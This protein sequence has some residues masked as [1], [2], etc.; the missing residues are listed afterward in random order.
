MSNPFRPVTIPQALETA[1]QAHRAGRLAEADALYRQILSA[2]PFHADALHFLGVIAGQTGKHVE[3]VEWFRQAIVRQPGNP[4]AHKNFSIA[5]K[6][7]GQVDEAISACR[8]AVAIKPDYPEAH[9]ILGGL[10]HAKGTLDEALAAYRQ[11]LALRPGYAESWSNL[12][13]VLRD[14]GQPDEAILACREAIALNNALPEAHSNLGNALFAQ[15]AFGA[16]VAAYRDALRLAPRFASAWNNLG[17]A[18]ESNG[19]IE[20][21]IGA[22]QK[23]IELRPEHAD[24]FAKLGHALKEQGRFAEAMDAYRK[25]VELKP[26]SPDWRHVLAALSGDSSANGTPATYVRTLFDSYA[27]DFD[28]D[29]VEKLAYHVP[30]MLLEAVL[31]VAPGRKFDILDLGCG[32]GLCGAQFRPHASHLSG[33]DLSPAMLAKALARGIYDRLITGDISEA[34]R[35]QENGFDLLLAGDLFVYVGDLDGVFQ[36]AALTLR[37]G[38]LLAFSL[39]RHDGEGFVLHSKIRFAHSLG[40]VRNLAQK[41]GFSERVANKI[42]VRKSGNAAVAGWLVVLQAP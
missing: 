5:L 20:E 2:E 39:E 15:R 34:M 33:V 10:Y 27:E 29:L 11:A 7:V 14:A 19:Q 22:Y 21:A 17:V 30:E 18:L 31:S 4:E 9:K 8:Q 6:A 16:A 25:A 37:S 12:G 24:G 38:G 13:A 23:S 36:S 1:L 40:Y 42:T 41:H 3:A 32:T 26:D 28:A 35:D